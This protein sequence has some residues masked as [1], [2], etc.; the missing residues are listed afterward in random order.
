DGPRL[1]IEFCRISETR[2]GALT[3][4]IDS[5]S[6]CETT[7]AWCLSKRAHTEDVIADLR[8]REGTTV[9]NIGHLHANTPP[10]QPEGIERV[11][12]AWAKEKEIDAVVW[13]ALHTNFEEKTKR[14]FSI[15]HAIAHIRSLSVDGKVKAAEYVWRAP[16]FVHT[17]LRA[18]LQK[19]PWFSES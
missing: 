15:E 7:A 16:D 14:P 3:L 5:K 18:A 9:Q 12:L 1:P 17:P 4:V 11:I 6:G 13:T 10:S 8:C 19:E 2:S